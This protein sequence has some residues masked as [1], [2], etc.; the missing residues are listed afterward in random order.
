MTWPQIIATL[1]PADKPSFTN[2]E[3]RTIVSR[4]LGLCS[5][6]WVNQNPD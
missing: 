2:A 5:D 3:V 6:N 4:A 1:V